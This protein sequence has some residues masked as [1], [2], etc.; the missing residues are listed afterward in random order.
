M[1][2][3]PIPTEP[4]ILTTTV[5]SYP[6]PD[7]LSALPSE[8]AVIDATRV[9]FDTQRQ[10]GIDLPT[11]GELSG[12]ARRARGP[13]FERAHGDDERDD[14][15]F[16]TAEFL[17]RL[18]DVRVLGEVG[19]E[20]V[21]EAP[22]ALSFALRHQFLEFLFETR[23]FAALQAFQHRSEVLRDHTVTSTANGVH[24]RFKTDT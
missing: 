16:A 17:Q 2:P 9:I 21:E 11:D 18:H 1:N 14:A 24:R 22:V 15:I 8:Q 19:V 23:G 13:R 20:G 3:S 7:W 4:G 12:T 5:G 10:S 6:V